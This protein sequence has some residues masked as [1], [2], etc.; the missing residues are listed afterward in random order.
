[1]SEK[2]NK[3]EETRL[4]SARAFEIANGDK[5]KT[6]V[7]EDRVLLSGDYVEVAQKEKEEDKLELE[8][9]KKK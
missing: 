2:L 8:I 5:P 3:F 6:D 4:L 7:E 9:Y 1:M